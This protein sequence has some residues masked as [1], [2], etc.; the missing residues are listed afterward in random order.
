MEAGKSWLYTAVAGSVADQWVN[1]HVTHTMSWVPH[2]LTPQGS[3]GQFCSSM[4]PG[5]VSR[6]QPGLQHSLTC[7]A[8]PPQLP[9]D[10][11]SHHLANVALTP[12]GK[13]GTKYLHNSAPALKGLHDLHN[14]SFSPKVTP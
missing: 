2:L 11:D 14:P 6:S 13:P 9:K 3:L 5:K 4:E 12:A 7:S 8:P 10:G 1:S